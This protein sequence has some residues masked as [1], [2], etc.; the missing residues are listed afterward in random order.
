MATLTTHTLNSV[1]GTHAGGIPVSL[2]RIEP[3]G[4]RTELFRS[5]TDDDGRLGQEVALDASMPHAGYEMVLETGPYFEA[6]GQRD[7]GQPVCSD[8]VFR[9]KMPDAQARYH[10]PFMLAPNSYS[11][12]WSSL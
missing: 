3:D 12:W 7:P 9:F 8:V 1:D 6:R 4:T 11:V 10:I 2:Y 5:A